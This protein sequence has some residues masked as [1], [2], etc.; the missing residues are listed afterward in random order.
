VLFEIIGIVLSMILMALVF[1]AMGA[2][3]NIVR[4][5]FTIMMRALGLRIAQAAGE[6]RRCVYCG[7]EIPGDTTYCPYCG[8]RADHS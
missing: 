4:G 1:A 6:G 5:N 7:E 2:G 8:S 3:M